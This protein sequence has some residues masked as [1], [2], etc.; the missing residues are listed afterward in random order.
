MKTCFKRTSLAGISIY[1]ALICN[2]LALTVVPPETQDFRSRL[3]T[4]EIARYLYLRTGELPQIV[5][6]LPERDDAI[7][8]ATDASLA[9]EAFTISTLKRSN[10]RIWTIAAADAQGQLYGAYRFVECL[11]VRFYLHG[12]VIPDETLKVLPDVN[13][14]QK[15]LFALRGIQPFHDFTEG[16]DWWNKDDWLSYV[17][18]LPKLRMNFIG[19]HCYAAKSAEPLVWIGTKEDMEADGKVKF[20]FPAAWANTAREQWGVKAEKTSKF[21]GGL[22]RLFPEDTYGNEVQEGLMP[23]PKTTEQC[24]ELFNRTAS[25][26]AATFN[27]AKSLGVKTCVGTETPLWIPKSVKERLNAQGITETTDMVNKAYEGIFTHIQKTCP[28]DYYWLW[29]P[30]EWTW[31]GN[32]KTEYIDTLNDIKAALGALERIGNPFT[33]ATCGWVLGPVHDRMAWD[34]ILPKVAPIACINSHLGGDPIEPTFSNVKG[35]PTWAVPWMENDPAMTQP[36]PWVGRMRYDAA[37][38][39]RLGCS[40]LFGIHWRAKAMMQNISAL[41][42]AGW[43]QSWVPNTFN[44]ASVS[45]SAN[46]DDGAIGGKSITLKTPVTGTDEPLVYQSIRAES[47]GYKLKVPDG[48]Y[49]VTL[50]FVEPSVEQAKKRVF[51][52]SIQRKNVIEALDIFATVGKNVALDR[53]FEGI[54]VDNGVLQIDFG[55]IA[56]QSCISGI[57]ID[58]M[59]KTQNQIAGQ[60]Y[61]RKINCGGDCLNDYEADRINQLLPVADQKRTMPIQDF[62]DDFAQANFGTTVAEAVAKIMV[63]VDGMNMP[64][65]TRWT[66]GPGGVV[67][68]PKPWEEVKKQFQFIESFALLRPMVNGVGN[69]ERF[70][71][72]LN[73][74]RAMELMAQAG[75]L[76]GELDKLVEKIMKEQDD[77]LKKQMATDALSIRQKMARTWETLM[78]VQTSICDTLGELGTSA[79][80][81]LHSRFKSKFLDEHDETIAKALGTTLPDNVTPSEKYTGLSRVIVPTV[82]TQIASTEQLQLKVLVVDNQAA[83]RINLFWRPLG[84]GE[85]QKAKIEH[86]NR[87]VYSVILPKMTSDFEYYIS[88]KVSSGKQ[89]VWPA[90]APQRNQSVLVVE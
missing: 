56:D 76:R 90:T 46:S 33:L 45:Q 84:R 28:V 51:S 25:M 38:A 13:E 77:S 22:A 9:P 20:S 47:K 11:G 10:G 74:Y 30:E 2:S 21:S 61:K 23:Y 81:E 35:R 59:T 48:T 1:T 66:R 54:D 50:K 49:R 64:V 67:P 43:D 8:F 15:P 40:G 7:V 58:G 53:T 32:T 27:C 82:R 78:S 87:G 29:T 79:N 52:V 65:V 55:R 70:D 85:Y 34:S 16:P 83:K 75:C 37:D 17:S 89:L 36:Q 41:A 18:Q 68:N 57:V 39:K 88:A 14:T 4:K 42:A 12:D 62:Y 31:K 63:S 24:N 26:L 6:R 44:M 60:P 80:L 72:W 19:L 86:V 71:Y 69:L 73:S 5:S 3:A